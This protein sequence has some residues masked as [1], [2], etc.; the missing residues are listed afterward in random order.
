MQTGVC[1][2][3]DVRGV[4]LRTRHQGCALCVLIATIMMV[5]GLTIAGGDDEVKTWTIAVYVDADNNFDTYWEDLSRLMFLNLPAREGLHILGYVDR[6]S[7]EGTEVQEISGGTV[8]VLDTYE[9]KNFGDGA[10][11]SWFL[12]DAYARYETD[13]M[14]VIAWDHGSAWGGFCTDDTSGGDKITLAEMQT[15]IVGAGVTIDILAFDAC[16]VGSIEASYQ[17]SLTGLVRY[18]VASEELVPGNGFPYDLMFTPLAN[19]VTR[20]PRDVA[21]DMVKGWAQYYDPLAWAWYATLSAIDIGALTEA[22][23]NIKAWCDAMYASLPDYYRNYRTAL[24]NSYY[25]SNSQYQTDLVDIGNHLLVDP[26]VTDA[27]LRTATELMIAAIEGAVIRVDN[28]DKSAACGG[29]SIYWGV[30]N[31][32]VFNSDAYSGISFP[33]DTCWWDF[34]DAYNA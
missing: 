24:R 32:W 19:D 12:T 6:L 27:T 9:E 5:P 16:A 18:M 29:I 4:T 22:M 14:A 17:A 10:T 25:V 11:F 23:P 13:F 28:T 20:C 8:A 26:A 21:C 33:T 30:R 7:V 2:K 3:V 1:E 34:L 31:Y 15:A